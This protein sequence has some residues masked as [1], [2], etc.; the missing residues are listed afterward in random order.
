MPLKKQMEN[1]EIQCT[2]LEENQQK[3]ERIQKILLNEKMSMTV[4]FH[5]TFTK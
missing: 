1:L 5:N 2:S 4:Y 3:L